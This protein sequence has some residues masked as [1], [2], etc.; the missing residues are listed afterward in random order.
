[1]GDNIKSVYGNAT[2]GLEIY[3]D[4][5]LGSIITKIGD[6]ALYIQS[7]FV[8]IG[9]E[10]ELMITALKNDTVE[11]YY[12]NSKKLG[13][14]NTGILVVGDGDYTGNIFLQDDKF[15][16]FG[17]NRDVIIGHTW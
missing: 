14:T 6:G 3:N 5:S 16:K 8:R 13:T 17:A 1:M 15:V 4:S 12:N 9:F 7:G 2:D 11:L 10:A